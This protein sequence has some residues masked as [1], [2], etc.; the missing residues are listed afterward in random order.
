MRKSIGLL[1]F[2]AAFFTA[3]SAQAVSIKT[4]TFTA[5]ASVAAVNDFTAVTRTLNAA[6]TL[7]GT[8]INFGAQTQ[9]GG[10]YAGFPTEYIAINVTD[11]APLWKMQIYSDNYTPVTPSTSAYGFQYGG[12]KGG[13]TTYGDKVSLIWLAS[14][15][16]VVGGPALGVSPLTSG[17]TSSWTYMKDLKDIDDPILVASDPA[18]VAGGHKTRL[19]ASWAL[20]QTAGYANIAFGGGSIGTSVVTTDSTTGSGVMRSLANPGDQ[21]SVYLRG[22]F[23]LAA[24]DT[25]TGNIKVELYHP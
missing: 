9:A 18:W 2:A 12:L 19:G 24:A 4:I 5:T 25:Y 3:V 7:V 11:N 13:A 10:H 1:L 17:A 14:T 20:A 22:D 8:A 16:T 6:N 23:S 21:I 15:M